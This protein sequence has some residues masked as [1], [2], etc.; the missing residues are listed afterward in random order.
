MQLFHTPPV[1]SAVFDE[2]NLVSAAGLVPL[3]ALARRAGLAQLADRWLSVPTD[4]GANAGVKVCSLVAGMA[5]GADSIDDMDLLRHGGMVRV[6]GAAP[7]PSTLGSF[8][9][10]MTFGHVR[11]L[12]AVASQFLVALAADTKLLGAPDARTRHGLIELG[13]RAA[14]DL[15]RLPFPQLM[16]TCPLVPQTGSGSTGGRYAT[17][18]SLVGSSSSARRG[19]SSGG[20]RTTIVAPL[21]T[22]RGCHSVSR[23]VVSRR[24]WTPHLRKHRDHAGQNTLLSASQADSASSILV[25]RSSVSAGQ[26]LAK[27]ASDPSGTLVRSARAITCHNFRPGRSRP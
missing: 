24:P 1:A 4:K 25:T 6:L 5:A 22:I 7:A 27:S 14:T 3:M 2:P 10:A 15:V 20:R 12:D 8:L 11:Q 23:G 19:H 18:G 13:L 26:R 17:V 21:R 16:F 9:R